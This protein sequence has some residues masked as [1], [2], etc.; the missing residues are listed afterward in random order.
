MH[1]LHIDEIL[2]M[3]F[4]GADARNHFGLLKIYLT[5]VKFGKVD[6]VLGIKTSIVIKTLLINWK[7]PLSQIPLFKPNR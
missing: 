2:L 4:L 7:I 3:K 1:Q 6:C 5:P